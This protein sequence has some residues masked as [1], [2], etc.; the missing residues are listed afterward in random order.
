MACDAETME[1]AVIQKRGRQVCAT[2]TS[3]VIAWHEWSL[4]SANESVGSGY[5]EGPCLQLHIINS[6][7][8]TPDQSVAITSCYNSLESGF[9]MDKSLSAVGG[10]PT[11][12]QR[13]E[14]NPD[15]VLANRD[16]GVKL[17]RHY[18]AAKEVV[19]KS[20]QANMFVPAITQTLE[21]YKYSTSTN[22]PTQGLL[23]SAYV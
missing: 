17:E 14:H 2:S 10:V 7:M 6:P 16:V 11:L 18:Q 13:E 23:W 4:G 22:L 15:D 20:V 3:S 19:L 9:K 1:T 21:C 5:G 8:P 12:Y